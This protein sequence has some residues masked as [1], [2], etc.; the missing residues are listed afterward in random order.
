MKKH[1]ISPEMSVDIM[2]TMDLLVESPVENGFDPDG[3]PTTGDTSGNLSRRNSW[4]D[5]DEEDF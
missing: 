4:D 5:D 2:D 3:R 1:Y